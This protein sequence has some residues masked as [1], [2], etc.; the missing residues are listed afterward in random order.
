MDGECGKMH[1]PRYMQVEDAG[2]LD[3]AGHV[4]PYSGLPEVYA[5]MMLGLHMGHRGTKILNLYTP[6]IHLQNFLTP[7]YNI[8]EL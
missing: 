7:Q 1:F 6:E 3:E 8:L 4:S 5:A 2:G